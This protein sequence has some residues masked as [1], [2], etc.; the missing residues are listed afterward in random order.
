MGRKALELA[1][2]Q[3]KPFVFT[4]HTQYEE[5]AHYFPFFTQFAKIYVRHFIKKFCEKCDLV[6]APAQGIKNILIDYGIENKIEIVPNGIDI[7]K[8]NPAEK[9]IPK[10]LENLNPNNKIAIFTGRIAKEKNLDFLFRAFELIFKE[11]PDTYLL[12]V[13]SG[14]EERDF[15]KLILDLGLEGKIIMVGSVPYHEIPKYYSLAELFVTAS[16]T[17][18]HPL[19]I[20]EAMASG[21]PVVA[22]DAPGTS[23]I[24]SHHRDGLLTPENEEN[25]AKTVIEVLKNDHLRLLMKEQALKTSRKYSIIETSKT[26]LEVYQDLI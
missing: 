2:R 18:V 14:P 20:L 22:V 1:E 12:V 9:D 16:T 6:I 3:K 4:N 21:L 11:C 24:I 26:L 10:S 19:T 13:G 7:K 5:Y 23:D 15:K 17:E 25:F 8:F